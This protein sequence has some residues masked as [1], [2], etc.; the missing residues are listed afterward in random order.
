[1]KLNRLS[2]ALL[3]TLALVLLIF[4]P[5]PAPANAADEKLEINVYRQGTS[6]DGLLYTGGAGNLSVIVAI[7]NVSSEPLDV[8]IKG[9]GI[10]I[11]INQDVEKKETI[12]L[13]VTEANL[14]GTPIT[15]TFEWTVMNGSS[16]SPSA[17]P[18][19]S[20]APQTGTQTKQVTVIRAAKTPEV[21]ITPSTSVEPGTEVTIT[22]KLESNLSGKKLE[23]IKI[24][25]SAIFEG[26]KSITSPSGEL[27]VK[28]VVNDSLTSQPTFTYKVEGDSKTYTTTAAAKQITV[29]PPDVTVSAVAS[30][31]EVNYG[32]TIKFTITVTNASGVKLTDVEIKDEKGNTI[33]SGK[34]VAAGGQ[35]THTNTVTIKG[36]RNASFTVKYKS[37]NGQTVYEK[38]TN[39]I[40]IRALNTPGP[41]TLEP[42]PSRV[43]GK[44]GISVTATPSAPESFPADV[45]FS[46]VINNEGTTPL[47]QLV[48]TE[49]TLGEIGRIE[50]LGSGSKTIEKEITLEEAGT[51][52]F[53]VNATDEYG[54][55]IEATSSVVTITQ[56]AATIT[57]TAGPSESASPVDML[58]TLLTIMAVI[59]V[60]IVLSAI[61]LVILMIIERQRRKRNKKGKGSKRTNDTDLFNGKPE[62]PK[63]FS[64]EFT[65]D[66]FEMTR[67]M[68]VE[69]IRKNRS[70]N[71]NYTI[72][73]EKNDSHWSDEIY[74]E[75][76]KNPPDDLGYLPPRNLNRK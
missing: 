37:G 33:T 15:L 35:L 27:E 25:D 57:P 20:P 43:P 6:S 23:N 10:T 19:E 1:M 50:M 34:E 14:N 9:K 47:L 29:L 11:S 42:T 8:E 5:A 53:E 31:S 38:T 62:K 49:K 44:V 65:E 36:N 67:K 69:S 18:E 56:P 12:T 7:K 46:I 16:P 48:V 72:D 4:Y 3:L 58:G 66:D 51:F 22:Y 39:T 30:N 24:T 61:V 75:G 2:I 76:K 17:S 59:I 32:E 55:I 63:N 26:E 60:L 40:A 28:K 71:F 41:T 52:E 64:M 74:N 73:E 70:G 21:D 13:N 68:P 54:N 45:T